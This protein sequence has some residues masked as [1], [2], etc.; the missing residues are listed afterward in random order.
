MHRSPNLKIVMPTPFIPFLIHFH[1]TF[2]CMTL[3]IIRGRPPRNI[4]S[5][6]LNYCHNC[7]FVIRYF[8]CA[9]LAPRMN[10]E[11]GF[12]LF[13]HNGSG[14]VVHHE[15]EQAFDAMWRPA[16][17]G[18]YPNRG[19]SPKREGETAGAPGKGGGGP[20]PTAVKAAAYRAPGSSGSSTVSDFMRGGPDPSKVTQCND[21]SMTW[22]CMRACVCL[23]HSFYH[24]PSPS[25]A[26][27]LSKSLHLSRADMFID[28]CP[29][30]F[31]NSLYRTNWLYPPLF[32]LI[33][34][35]FF[36]YY[37]FVSP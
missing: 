7:F 22:T 11:N 2:A 31:S 13:R 1:F 24:S 37:V 15:V 16:E 27:L 18:I 19:P 5:Y 17:A 20:V 3:S 35:F 14:P 29:W 4:E 32:F 12:K 30:I 33:S 8:M 26:L 34:F 25:L 23:S 6:R 21:Q 10:V 28:S 36:L 9:T